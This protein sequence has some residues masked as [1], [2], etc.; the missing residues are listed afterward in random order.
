V[1]KQAGIESDHSEAPM[2]D[3][4]DIDALVKQLAT[5]TGAPDTKHISDALAQHGGEIDKLLEKAG[6]I[7]ST[8][9][10]MDMAHAPT[11]M[12]PTNKVM[13]GG[14]APTTILATT[15]IRGAHWLLAAVLV[16]L[17]ICSV[18]LMVIVTSINGLTRELRTSHPSALAPSD[19]FGDDL[20]AAL[21]KLASPD[22]GEMTKGVL[23]LQRLKNLH[24]SHLTEISLTLIR[25]FREHGAYRQAVAEF[26]QLSDN[27]NNLFENPRL[28]LDYAD[29][30]TKTDDKPGAL[31]QV[32]ILLANESAY[33]SS[34]DAHNLPRSTEEIARNH[35]VIQDGYLALG[36]LLDQRPTGQ[37]ATA[38]V[39]ADDQA[40]FT[41]PPA[42][43][44]AEPPPAPSADAAPPT[45]HAT[46]AK[47]QLKPAEANLNVG[48]PA[49]AQVHP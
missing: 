32:Y 23:F 37:K 8:S 49:A 4:G 10:A 2:I 26:A 48:V 19:S 15:E 44:A 21:A 1:S 12:A 18:S 29:S 39:V 16:F 11:L 33:L 46:P 31:R 42:V 30:L 25:H 6:E 27:T 28:Y 43:V 22:D 38:P 9:D 47:A 13:Q 5:A 17:A 35:Q 41:P 3:Q 45:D 24:P 7:R 34:R 36:Q 20:K 40:Q 14:H